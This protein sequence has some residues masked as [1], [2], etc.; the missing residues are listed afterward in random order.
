[1]QVLRSKQAMILLILTLALCL[2]W[3]VSASAAEKYELEKL[4][5]YDY[6]DMDDSITLS[7]SKIKDSMSQ[8]IEWQTVRIRANVSNGDYEIEGANL[9]GKY[10]VVTLHDEATDLI[11]KIRDDDGDVQKRYYLQLRQASE[12]LEAV[13][14]TG[15]DY[16]FT[17]DTLASTNVLTIPS[18]VDELEMEVDVTSS[19][20]IVKYNTRESDDNTWTIDVPEDSTIPLYI[21]VSNE[22]DP[23]DYTQYKIEV[24][25]LSDDDEAQGSLSALKVKSGSAS[26]DLFP[27]F[28]PEIYNYYVLVPNGAKTVTFTP[29]LGNS[30]TSVTVN[31]ELV[32]N[33][34]ASEEITA[35]TN[36]SQ[37]TL[38]VTDANEQ[39]NVYTI[40][41][42]RTTKSEGDEAEMTNLR[43]KSGTS[44]KLDALLM[45]DT[46]PAFDSDRYNYELV[47]DAAYG[48]FAF[49]PSIG[50][51]N[52]AALLLVDNKVI[53]L[54]ESNY[55]DPIQLGID[56]E[57]TIRVYSADFRNTQDYNFTVAARE[58]D[59]NYL[60]KGLELRLDGVKVVLSPAFSGTTYNYTASGDDTSKEYTVT[61]TAASDGATIEVN[62]DK[63][64]SGEASDEYELGT[65][66]ST[67]K[68]KVTAE[69]GESATYKLTIDR[70]GIVGDKIVLRIGSTSYIA[71][72]KTLSLA[73]AP[74]I[75]NSRTQVPVR[76]IAESL[77]ASVHYDN[78]H[79]QITIKKGDE[80]MYMD[81]GKVIKDFDVAPEIKANT[82]FVP[83]RYVSEKLNCKCV[84]NSDSKEIIITHV[85]EED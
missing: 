13:T 69:N 70:S 3:A 39:I 52:G 57:A 47:M 29:T 23:D 80:R 46:V 5:L 60:L 35:S 66:S 17:F 50:D 48:Y 75:S 78:V 54:S 22:D 59:D 67:V 83:I 16:E 85:A 26:Y 18:R 4:Y 77:G 25:R 61:A 11:I 33:G 71:N 79:K 51:S 65:T 14:F 64:T 2:G 37:V 32:A 84:Y 44:K 6:S 68:I 74:Y 15:D 34:K 7:D 62:G 73:A 41:L 31:G 43:V 21:T 36:G 81:I 45:V 56:S 76:V 10:Y 40:N 42:L 12:G 38:M 58:L 72:G 82:T 8:T 55:C 9:D 53:R 63:V 1:M 24:T 19:D 20:Y 28:D 30:G 27:E 49:R